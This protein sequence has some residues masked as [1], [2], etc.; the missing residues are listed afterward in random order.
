M[1]IIADDDN[2]F[3]QLNQ[4]NSIIATRRTILQVLQ[5]CTQG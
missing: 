1:Q 2:F 3:R 4:I 5:Y